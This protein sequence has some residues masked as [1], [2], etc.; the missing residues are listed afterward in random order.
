VKYA[1]I[2]GHRSEF[3]V[4][5]MCRVLQVHFSGF[6]AWLKSPLSNRARKDERQT[7]LI[8]QA[9]KDSGKVYG[10]R[11]LHDDLCDQGEQS[12]PNSLRHFAV[13]ERQDSVGFFVFGQQ[14]A[15]TIGGSQANFA[16]VDRCGGGTLALA[17]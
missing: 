11:K 8:K 1:F 15:L 13:A 17:S 4:R 10:Y 9:W 5:A 3:A 6:Y 12:S 7:A 2:E 14:I 16:I